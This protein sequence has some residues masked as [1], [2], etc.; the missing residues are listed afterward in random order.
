MEDITGDARVALVTGAARR[1]GAEIVRTLHA[2]GWRIA[3]HYRSAAAEA[4]TLAS[5]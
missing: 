3:L 4:E 5:N 1:V 2:T